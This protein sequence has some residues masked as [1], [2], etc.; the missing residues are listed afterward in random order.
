MAQ[1]NLSPEQRLIDIENK[2]VVAQG[3]G[4]PQVCLEGVM[5]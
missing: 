2:L 4:E 3:E 1:M 5:N